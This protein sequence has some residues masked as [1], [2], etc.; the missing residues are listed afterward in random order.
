MGNIIEALRH[1]FDRRTKEQIDPHS[2]QNHPEDT[3]PDQS[4]IVTETQQIFKPSSNEVMPIE[5]TIP[6]AT[7][8]AEASSIPCSQFYIACRTNNIE[9]VKRLLKTM[10]LDE[11]D[12]DYPILAN[13][14]VL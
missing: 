8:G 6:T 12:R 13:P 3:S 7:T 1:I 2:Q 14:I 9:D 10:K 5:K 11:I 4:P